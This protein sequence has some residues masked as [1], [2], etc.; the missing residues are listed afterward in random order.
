[1]KPGRGRRLAL[2]AIAAVLELSGV[3]ASAEELT[4]ANLVDLSAGY[5]TTRLEGTGVINEKEQRIGTIIDFVVVRDLPPA[6][7]VDVAGFLGIRDHLV[8]V[9][10]KSFVFDVT[11]RKI[12]L[13]GATREALRNFPEFKFRD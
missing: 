6:A 7:I 11:G 9:P 2:T 5:R 13:P 3:S 12:I 4:S 8:A 10:F 1:M